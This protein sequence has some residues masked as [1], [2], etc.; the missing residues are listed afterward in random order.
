[1]AAL[2]DGGG[3]GSGGVGRSGEVAPT[4]MA[5]RVNA[6]VEGSRRQTGTTGTTSPTSDPTPAATEDE[7][8]KHADLAFGKQAASK[9]SDAPPPNH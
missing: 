6:V 1:M 5:Q 7:L 4:V 9:T 3:E 8:K 2:E